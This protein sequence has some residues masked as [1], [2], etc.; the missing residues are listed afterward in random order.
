MRFGGLSPV[1]QHGYDSSM[2]T[3]HSPPARRGIY[4]FR[5]PYIEPFLLGSSTGIGGYDGTSNRVKYLLKKDGT[6][7]TNLDS[8]FDE[9]WEKKDVFT[10]PTNE[11]IKANSTDFSGAKYYLVTWVDRPKIFETNE[12]VWHHL[13][14][15]LRSKNIIK[16][17]GSWVLTSMN[18]YI[19]AFKKELHDMASSKSPFIEGQNY[20]YTNNPFRFHSKDHLEV[21]FEKI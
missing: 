19:N 13:G 4:A 8:E 16:R 21:F 3:F 11:Y 14:H 18:N 9:T 6:R 17:K 12:D 15:H 1:K 2:P 7:I 10:Q 20:K 5:Y